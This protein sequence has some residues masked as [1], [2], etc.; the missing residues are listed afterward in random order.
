MWHWS[1][2]NL[3]TPGT[4]RAAC[5]L[6]E[7]ILSA[8]LLD[9]AHVAAAVDAT[10]FSDGLSGPCALTDSALSLWSAVPGIKERENVGSVQKVGIR[11][12]HWL[13]SNW[14]LRKWIFPCPR[15]VLTPT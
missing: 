10:L 3:S 14:T 5:H 4:S 13:N 11:V 15:A 12:V 6:L 9:V 7:S 2:R 1:A 8:E